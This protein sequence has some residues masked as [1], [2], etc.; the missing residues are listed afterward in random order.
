[1][2]M[3]CGVQ[4]EIP[5]EER[6]LHLHAADGARGAREDAHFAGAE[7]ERARRRLAR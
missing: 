2:L 1:M 6:R 7:A 4:G 5:R 3:G